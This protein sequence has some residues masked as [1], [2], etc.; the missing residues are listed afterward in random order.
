M[1]ICKIYQTNNEVVSAMLADFDVYAELVQSEDDILVSFR[2]NTITTPDNS[3]LY[4]TPEESGKL[5]NQRFDAV[6]Y[7]EWVNLPESLEHRL[8]ELLND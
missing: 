6:E 3:V 4:I 1:K 8:M 7:N 2:N 5:E